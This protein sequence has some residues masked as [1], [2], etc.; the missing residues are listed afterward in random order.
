M[1]AM[2]ISPVIAMGVV[3][4]WS[5][6]YIMSMMIE[7]RTLHIVASLTTEIRVR[8]TL[9]TLD[10]CVKPIVEDLCVVEYT[11]CIPAEELGVI[12]IM[13]ACPCLHHL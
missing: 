12:P 6:L 8:P 11:S 5:I 2:F 1:V 13:H 9:F 4:I 3:G 10:G 7:V